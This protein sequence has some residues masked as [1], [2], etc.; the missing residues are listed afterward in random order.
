[1]ALP[2]PHSYHL[3]IAM[4]LNARNI[5]MFSCWSA[6][7]E[8]HQGL[9]STMNS[10]PL[11]RSLKVTPAKPTEGAEGDNKGWRY[12]PGEPVWMSRNA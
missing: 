12:C 1:M 9:D 7:I 4:M 10:H 11:K 5:T 2:Q 8:Q 3:V 6:F